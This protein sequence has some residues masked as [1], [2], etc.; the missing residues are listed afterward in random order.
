MS[1]QVPVASGW[2]RRYGHG[3]TSRSVASMGRCWWP[4]SLISKSSALHGRRRIRI[5]RGGRS[6]LRRPSGTDTHALTLDQGRNCPRK[7]PGATGRMKR[8]LDVPDYPGAG[9]ALESLENAALPPRFS[10]SGRL[11]GLAG[12]R[13]PAAWCFNPLST[14]R[15]R[16][17]APGPLRPPR[18]GACLPPSMTTIFS[19][20]A[21]KGDILGLCAVEAFPGDDVLRFRPGCAGDGLP[22]GG[23]ARD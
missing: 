17:A 4:Q 2:R 15:L 8:P 11:S 21:L 22:R 16:T 5:G 10:G 9:I 23:P 19:L 14:D 6:C 7:R 3:H 1:C 20:A 13:R 12:L 18:H